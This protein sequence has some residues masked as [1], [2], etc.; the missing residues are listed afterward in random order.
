M[1]HALYIRAR[2]RRITV[3][4][5]AGAF[6]AAGLLAPTTAT[7]DDPAPQ[8]QTDVLGGTSLTDDGWTGPAASGGGYDFSVNDGTLQA[9]NYGAS[10]VITQLESPTTAEAGE[11]GYTDAG[12]DSYHMAFTLDG[13]AVGDDNYVAQPG[14]SLEVDADEGG[15]RAGGGLYFSVPAD[16]VL[17]VDNFSATDPF[18]DLWSG[19]T[20]RIPFTG[21]IAIDYTVTFV[22][23]G[24]D[25]VTVKA[26]G[27]TILAP[28]ANVSSAA[29]SYEGYSYAVAAGTDATDP[30]SAPDA[31]KVDQV[32]FRATHNAFNTAWTPSNTDPDVAPWAPLS[33]P[34]PSTPGGG[35]TFS[36]L[37]YGA[38]NSAS[39]AYAFRSATTIAA[40]QIANYED[41]MTYNTWHIGSN[42]DSTDP[43]KYFNVLSNGDIQL[44]DYV[45]DSHSTQLLKGIPTANQPTDLYALVS[46]GLA[47]TDTADA[48]ATYQLALT[49]ANVAH[50]SGSVG[51]T[52]LH[53]ESGSE[54]AGLNVVRLSDPWVST[55]AIG[56]IAANTVKPLGELLAAL[57]PGATTD[58]DYASDITAADV[59]VVGFGVAS[60]ADHTSAEVGAI[61][62]DGGKYTFAPVVTLTKPTI[63]GTVAIGHT[64]TATTDVD[65]VDSTLTYQWY[66]NG[67]AIPSATGHTHLVSFS[68]YGTE[69]SVKVT[70]KLTGYAGASATS[71]RTAPVGKGTITAD[72]PVT[73][74]STSP[75]VGEAVSA[76]LPNYDTQDVTGNQSSGITMSYQWYRGS[77][78]L[79]GA[80]HRSYTPVAAD[81]GG[82][83]SV[84][85]TAKKTD[86]TSLPLTSAATSAV[87]P[88]V[89]DVT[90]VPT[91]T[92]TPKDGHT[93]TAHSTGWTANGTATSS[94]TRR[95]FWFVSDGTGTPDI[96]DLVKVSTSNTLVLGWW[97]KGLK[98][99]VYVSGV[100][101]GYTS[102]T[103]SYSAFTA[104]VQ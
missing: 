38:Q 24:P 58:S 27:R 5:V 22:A 94:E 74:S 36:N 11:P 75:V 29:G 18:G 92:G 91:I 2:L 81:L 61:Y 30:A 19:A 26:N 82:S 34:V 46:Q 25:V 103:S 79:A 23:G 60:E 66:R 67:I 41:S 45:V 47:W 9:S 4:T 104:I 56:T 52:T 1:F 59:N 68:D 57:E 96:S 12:Y 101:N 13:A 16:H 78:P 40:N 31:D 15:N 87:T 65:P 8:T 97:A 28:V 3:I 37:T 54:T 7:A 35:F 70:A 77:T 6:V 72:G 93:L 53:P 98:V 64:L 89:L 102:A 85:A 10:G 95:Y 32:L 44:N 83:L 50:S 48:P 62:F 21:P 20:T 76:V 71:S 42:G 43:N 33:D 99:S 100:E 51:F 63:T 90:A 86:Y 80:T 14:V 55:H 17:E 88:G 39:Q 73:L 69:L 49:G 84:K